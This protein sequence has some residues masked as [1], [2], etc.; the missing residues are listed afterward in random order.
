MVAIVAIALHTL[1]W[2]FAVPVAAATGSLDPFSVICHVGTDATAAA[3]RDQGAPTSKPSAACDHCNLCT[4]TPTAATPD[5]VV[6]GRLLPERVLAVLSPAS[7]ERR[8]G[9][10]SDPKLARGPPQLM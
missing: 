6:S 5:V 3:D 10:A 9:V 7:V 2:A 8:E 1:L 4:A